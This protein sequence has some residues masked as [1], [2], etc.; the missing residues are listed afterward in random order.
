MIQIVNRFAADCGGGFLDLPTWYKFLPRAGEDKNP[1][2]PK[3]SSINDIWLVLLGVTDILLRVAILVAI[4]YV[5]IGGFKYITS[6]GNPDKTSTAKKTVI[7]G[8]IGMVIAIVA[9]TVVAFIAT[10]F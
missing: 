10:R 6:E 7:D 4:V 1:C 3:L 2:A 5:L 9:A 8:L